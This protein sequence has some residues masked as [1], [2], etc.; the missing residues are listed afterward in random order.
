MSAEPMRKR[1]AL[2]ITGNPAKDREESEE[3]VDG[4]LR[5]NIND[6]TME[7]D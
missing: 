5:L 1:S 2:T 6:G 3:I 7:G 4:L